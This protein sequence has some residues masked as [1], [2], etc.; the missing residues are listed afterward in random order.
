MKSNLKLEKVIIKIIFQ[1]FLTKYANLGSFDVT[2]AVYEDNSFTKVADTDYEVAVPDHV[3]VGVSGN[4]LG[5]TGYTVVA[6]NCW[7]T[8]DD[9]VNNPIK[10]DALIDGCP[11]PDVS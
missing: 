9:D 2:M 6:K 3:N 7:V 8:P 4:N 11:N 10:Y 5:D 1:L